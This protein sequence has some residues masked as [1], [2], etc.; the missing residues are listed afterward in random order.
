MRISPLF[1]LVSL[2]LLPDVMTTR[3]DIVLLQ[4]DFNNN[5]LDPSKWR[6]VLPNIPGTPA[7][8]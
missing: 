2:V 4:D 3:A 1:V 8:G 5:S 6:V 7:G